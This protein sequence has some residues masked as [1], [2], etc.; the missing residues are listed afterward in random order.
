MV[1]RRR[2]LQILR[3][4]ELPLVR[5]RNCV[6]RVFSRR[7]F[8]VAKLYRRARF[9]FRR[10]IRAGS[11]RLIER[12]QGA[13]DDAAVFVRA[14]VIHFNVGQADPLLQERVLARLGKF[15]FLIGGWQVGG[16]EGRDREKDGG[17]GPDKINVT[18]IGNEIAV[19]SRNTPVE[20]SGDLPSVSHLPM[21]VASAQLSSRYLPPG[22]LS[23]FK[24]AAILFR[25]P[26]ARIAQPWP[27]SPGGPGILVHLPSAFRTSSREQPKYCA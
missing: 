21:G 25:R 12:H 19:C 10:L 18:H 8:L 26:G 7:H 5:A 9:D 11:P 6:E 16:E 2:R 27:S 17:K 14:R 4:H 1:R 24:D 13:E 22:T 23:I 20:M 15:K 3:E